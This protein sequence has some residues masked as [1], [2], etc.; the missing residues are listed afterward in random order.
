MLFR[1][2]MLTEAMSYIPGADLF[3]EV[4]GAAKTLQELL[5]TVPKKEASKYILR[6][7]S[8]GLIKASIGLAALMLAGGAVMAIQQIEARSS[9][10]N[11]M[12]AKAMDQ[13]RSQQELDRRTAEQRRDFE[14]RVA[15]VRATYWHAIPPKEQYDRWM[16]VYRGIPLSAQGW[17]PFEVEC[18]AS[19]CRVRW[20]RKDA[21]ALPSAAPSLPGAV[22]KVT[23]NEVVTTFPVSPAQPLSWNDP[24]PPYALQ[25]LSA[26]MSSTKGVT[27]NVM[28]AM[29]PMN[30]PSSIEGVPPATLGTEGLWSISGSQAA[31]IPMLLGKMTFPGVQA[32][33]IKL[34][35]I[36]SGAPGNVEIHG[37]YRVTQ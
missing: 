23:E 16:A 28:A 35:A 9:A 22:E 10:E 21:R 31:L 2:D 14:A 1:S 19:T 13:L 11:S 30:V 18:D 33:S 12:M 34:T 25:D 4:P 20:M 29:S 37:R 3:G 15:T 36:K 17:V 8:S 24:L 26:W 27:L 6:S 32:G 7:A 5:A